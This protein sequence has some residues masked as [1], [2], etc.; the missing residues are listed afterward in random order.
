MSHAIDIDR[1]EAVLLVDGWHQVYPKTFDVGPYQFVMASEHE[2]S[3]LF[4]GGAG[5]RFTEQDGSGGLHRLSG[6]VAA[7]LAV[8]YTRQTDEEV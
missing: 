4:D 2:E 8:R 1:V 3:V 5:F 6:P 7:L